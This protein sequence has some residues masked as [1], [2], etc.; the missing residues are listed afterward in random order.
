MKTTIRIPLRE[1]KAAK[2][3]ISIL[4]TVFDILKQKPLTEISVKEV[5]E[6]IMI[7][8]GTFYNYFPKKSDLLTYFIQLWTI[9][10]T[11]YADRKFGNESGLGRIEVMLEKT[12][13]QSM[14]NIYI[15]GEIISLMA[16]SREMFDFPAISDA[17]KIIAFPDK[18]D[19][20]KVEPLMLHDLF[21]FNIEL[22]VKL[23]ELPEKTDIMLASLS[24]ASI[25][26]G[27]PLLLLQY[28][29]EL[30][31][32]TYKENLKLLWESL[33]IKYKS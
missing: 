5:C 28:K 6:M 27:V 7:S 16:L 2:T 10:V 30:L 18:E 4:W 14:E 21:A 11:W 8:D 3:K 12:A 23:G 13:Q 9:D 26:F 32:A 31:E 33:R 1:R 19:I 15:M 17:E 25:F 24:V 22:A 20:F 29:P